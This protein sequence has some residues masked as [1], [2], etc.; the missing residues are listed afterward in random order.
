MTAGTMKRPTPRTMRRSDPGQRPVFPVLPPQVLG[1][2]DGPAG[3]QG[4]KDIDKQDVDG[5][6]QGD[7][8]DGRLPHAGDHDGIRHP[9]RNQQD[10]LHHQGE[11]EAAQLL[12]GKHHI[13]RFS[14]SCHSLYFPPFGRFSQGA[15]ATFCETAKKEAAGRKL[16]GKKLWGQRADCAGL[17][18]QT[19][20][21][22]NR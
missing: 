11:D 12:C 19:M 5:I 18:R 2:D 17:F 16:L 9:H 6:H 10:L 21:L 7:G 22:W 3:A 15:G 8:G 13:Q 14:F 20:L 1:G 4:G